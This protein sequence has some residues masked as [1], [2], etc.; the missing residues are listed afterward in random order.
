M[1]AA[2]EWG[3]RQR[4]AAWDQVFNRL[5]DVV[6][7]R[8]RQAT[9]KRTV[10]AA[11]RLHKI[12]ESELEALEG[13]KDRNWKNGGDPVEKSASLANLAMALERIARADLMALGA[14]TE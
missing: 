8:K 7:V 9:E 2:A 1:V 12:I 5:A 11:V 3:W 13:M 4:A 6:P 10:E 14:E